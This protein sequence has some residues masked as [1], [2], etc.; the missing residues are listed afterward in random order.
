MTNFDKHNN[1][2]LRN[3]NNRANFLQFINQVTIE[4]KIPNFNSLASLGMSTSAIIGGFIVYAIST[5]ISCAGSNML[6]H[7][8]MILVTN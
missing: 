5:K 6:Y 1:F 2:N 4:F 7:F 8:D 3:S